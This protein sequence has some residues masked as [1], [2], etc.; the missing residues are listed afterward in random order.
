MA[1]MRKFR[2]DKLVRDE[3][4]SKMQEIGETV[5][6]RVLDDAEILEAL[7]DKLIEEVSEFDPKSPTALDELADLKAVM[8]QAA[9]EL[10]SGPEE[11]QKLQ[12]KKAA[13][14]GG[15]AARLFVETVTMSDDDPWAAYYAAEPERFPEITLSDTTQN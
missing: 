10:G 4:V 1:A 14:S 2:L 15:F 6:Y 13:R 5:Q 7:R 9:A 3:L 11:L 12:D 8:D